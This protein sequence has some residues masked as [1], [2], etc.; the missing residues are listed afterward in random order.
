M[1]DWTLATLLLLVGA[2]WL[3]IHRFLKGPSLRAYDRP[4][5]KRPGGR[6]AAS[7][8]H[9]EAVRLLEQ[10]ATEIRSAPTKQRLAAIRR[11]MARGFLDPSLVGEAEYRIEETHAG[12]V[13]GEWVLAPRSDPNRRVLYLHGGAFVSG[14]PRGHRMITTRLARV[15]GAAVLALDYRLMPEHSRRDMIADCQ[16][17]YR[18]ILDHGP[19]GPAPVRELFVAGDSAGGNLALMLVAWARDAGLRAANGAMALSPSVDM[20]LS[21]PT[22]KSNLKTDLMLGPSLRWFVRIPKTFYLLMTWLWSRMV[23]P[24]PL[25]SPVFGDLSRLPP[26]LV[27]VSEAEMMLGDARRY[28]N[29]ARAAGSSAELETWPDMLHVWHIFEP[30]LPEAREAFERIGQFVERCVGRP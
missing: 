29:K 20:T 12:G 22:F 5:E 9:Q 7:A 6:D 26:V 30:I 1:L 4:V 18:W 14:C 3:L 24:N 13:P 27:Q 21:S 11:V 16:A 15:A 10:A 23:P 2:A 28:V 19:D 25:I 8:D 17:G